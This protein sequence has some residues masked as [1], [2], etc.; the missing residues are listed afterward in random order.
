MGNCQSN[1][2]KRYSLKLD[3][4][5]LKE[6]KSQKDSKT[7]KI[8][9][10]GAGESGKSTIAKQMKIINLGGYTKEDKSNYKKIIYQ[11]VELSIRL[12]NDAM[13]N[14]LLIFSDKQNK[15]E[16]DIVIKEMDERKAQGLE[17][18]NS[19]MAPLLN[20]IWNDSV[21]AELMGRSN[22]FYM[23]DSTP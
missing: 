12:L 7:V 3:A 20:H 2:G 11:N 21:I 17:P 4:E 10:L 14:T 6:A 19:S 22:E 9:L 18:L 8:L 13:H 5:I 23:L 15:L 1:E 16:M